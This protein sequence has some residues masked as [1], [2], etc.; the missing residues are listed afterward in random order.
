[1]RKTSNMGGWE[2]EY[3]ASALDK[4][5]RLRHDMLDNDYIYIYI[6]R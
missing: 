2:F 5:V 3:N 4:K 6:F 1:M